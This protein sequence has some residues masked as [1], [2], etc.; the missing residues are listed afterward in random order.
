MKN[1]KKIAL[2]LALILAFSVFAFSVSASAKGP[3]DVTY[4]EYVTLNALVRATNT[5][6][7]ALVRVAQLTPFNDVPWLLAAVSALT[8]VVFNY[9][10]SIGAEIACSYTEYYIDGQYVLIDP[11]WVVNPIVPP[12]N[13][14]P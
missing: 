14:K 11:I 7:E 13:T 3:D 5:T 8:A 4:A 12:P 1:T 9:A 2:L 6:I 10:E